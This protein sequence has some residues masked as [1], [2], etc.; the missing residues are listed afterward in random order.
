MVTKPKPIHAFLR[1]SPNPAISICSGRVLCLLPVQYSHNV[2]QVFSN[3]YILMGWIRCNSTYL[4]WL[5]VPKGPQRRSCVF[6][7][8]RYQCLIAYWNFLLE[9][10]CDLLGWR[11]KVSARDKDDHL[12]RCWNVSFCVQ[13][14][15]KKM[16]LT[17][18]QV[19]VDYWVTRTGIGK[20]STLFTL[21][22]CWDL[23]LLPIHCKFYRYSHFEN[24]S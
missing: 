2:L 3:W 9:V 4:R 24:Y 6:S 1:S 8:C 18:S 22:I 14:D 20:K 11:R 13:T 21:I 19:V 15:K 10:I 16:I 5:V 7:W 23:I 17:P 12:D